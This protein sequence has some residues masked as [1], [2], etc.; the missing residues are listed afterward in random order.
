MLVLALTAVAVLGVGIGATGIGGVG[1]APVLIELWNVP[2][3]AAVPTCLAAFLMTGVI[4][5]FMH[6]R[7]FHAAPGEAVTIAL[8]CTVGAIAGAAVF[9]FISPV[10]IEYAIGL[11]MLI[12]GGLELSRGKLMLPAGGRGLPRGIP[13]L[14]LI[15]VAVGAGSALTGTGGPV[16]YVPLMFLLGGEVR[17]TVAIAQL[18][19]I[20]IAGAATGVYLAREALDLYLVLTIGLC[21]AVGAVAGALLIQRLNTR[22]LRKT[23][24]LCMVFGGIGFLSLRLS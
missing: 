7:S 23:I 2:L 1:L 16:L 17:N 22:I 21:L 14:A 9:P 10:Y 4:G 13:P 18:I 8:A 19:Q 3:E 6:R 5:V 24:G 11:L 15:G 12:G 20:P